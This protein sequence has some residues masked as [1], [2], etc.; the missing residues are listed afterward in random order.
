MVLP[1]VSE[2]SVPL[3]RVGHDTFADALSLRDGQNPAPVVLVLPRRDR[4]PLRVAA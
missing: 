2:L 4:P 1:T 3:Q